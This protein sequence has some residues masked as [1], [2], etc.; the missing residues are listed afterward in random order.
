[1]QAAAPKPAQSKE[2]DLQGPRFERRKNASILS[3]A[4]SNR[5][6]LRNKK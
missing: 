1:M 2:E 3:P 5:L 4:E 6:A